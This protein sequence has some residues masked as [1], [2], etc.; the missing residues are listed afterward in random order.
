MHD[1]PKHGQEK[2]L[3]TIIALEKR[4]GRIEQLLVN[5]ARGG[6]FRRK[7]AA[8]L[9]KLGTFEHYRP[10][11]LRSSRYFSEVAPANL[12]SIQI[13]TPSYNQ[14]PFIRETIESVLNQNYPKLTYAIQDCLSDDGTKEIIEEYK[15]RLVVR[16]E[17][18][19]G[20]ANGL[21]RAFEN[22]SSDIM[23]YLNSDDLLLSGTLAYVADY[24]ARHSEVDVVYGH[25]VIIDSQTFEIGRWVLPHHDA[26]AVKW[27]DYI[28]QETMFWRKRVWDRLG[29]FDESFQYALDWDFILRAQSLGFKFKRLPRF[30]GCFRVHDD[31]KTSKILDIGA[32]EMRQ[33]RIRHLGRRFYLRPTHQAI[34][35]YVLQHIFLNLLY[36]AR[37][38]RY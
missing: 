15:D 2:L 16:R 8:F 35:R 5:H 6:K 4:L 7:V 1:R 29:K 34:R 23:G 36:R 22:A 27:V 21:N 19:T 28:P 26:E 32:V 38:L 14:A 10:R 13:V 20:Q 33:L 30:L 3:E 12:P 37:I 31:Q 25:R 9:V 11:E 24:F 17:P 18:D